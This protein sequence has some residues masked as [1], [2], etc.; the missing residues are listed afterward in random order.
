[1]LAAVTKV[2]VQFCANGTT[3]NAAKHTNRAMRSELEGLQ[4]I[5]IT[6]GDMSRTSA[7]SEVPLTTALQNIVMQKKNSQRVYTSGA[8]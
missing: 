3:R 2:D 8:I 5:T 1:M 4:C 6:R 7:M